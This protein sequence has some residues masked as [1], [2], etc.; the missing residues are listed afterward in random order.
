[1][2]GSAPVGSCG[3]G[4]PRISREVQTRI[5][6]DALVSN[7]SF[8]NATLAAILSS[9]SKIPAVANS[10]LPSNLSKSSYSLHE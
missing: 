9:I 10:R 7:K 4:V 2:L 1:M 5:V 8:G 3:Q 6:L